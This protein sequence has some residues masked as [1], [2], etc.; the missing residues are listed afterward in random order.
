MQPV[1]KETGC[2][3]IWLPPDRIKAK[4][5]PAMNLASQRVVISIVYPG[6][7]WLKMTGAD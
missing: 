1:I 3:G 4:S 5:A 7:G 2:C 6:T